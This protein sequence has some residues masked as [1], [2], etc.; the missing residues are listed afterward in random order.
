MYLPSTILELNMWKVTSSLM[1][2]FT[3]DSLQVAMTHKWQKLQVFLPRSSSPQH[4][5]P[6]ACSVPVVPLR[7]HKQRADWMMSLHWMSWEY[8]SLHVGTLESCINHDVMTKLCSVCCS[9]CPGMCTV[10]IVWPTTLI[11]YPVHKFGNYMAIMWQCGPGKNSIYG[12][13]ISFILLMK[14]FQIVSIMQ[15]WNIC[16]IS[17]FVFITETETFHFISINPLFSF[18]CQ[19]F[20]FIIQ[21]HMYDSFNNV[22]FCISLNTQFY[23]FLLL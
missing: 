3:C 4:P 10:C 8:Y 5:L 17:I 15:T 1:L 13:L 11:L 12:I 20:W 7:V 18:R 22:A 6:L 2:V 14:Q 19:S 21:I 9:P 23:Q 16:Q